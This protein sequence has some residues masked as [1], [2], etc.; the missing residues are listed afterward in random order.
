MLDRI[1]ARFRACIFIAFCL[2]LTGCSSSVEVRSIDATK[3][4]GVFIVG[5][6]ENQG[7]RQYFETTLGK[8]LDEQ[9][10]KVFPSYL[11]IPDVVNSDAETVHKLAQ[12]KQAMMVLVVSPE[13]YQG[14]IK[15]PV[16]P[17]TQH[18]DLAKFYEHQGDKSSPFDP[19]K[20]TVAEVYV[21]L[22]NDEKAPYY[23]SGISMPHDTLSKEKALNDVARNLAKSLASARDEITKQLQNK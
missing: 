22:V 2:S 4:S 23:W 19:D 17:P 6:S 9:G 15:L 18:H 7:S 12:D 1:F 20:Q 8:Y 14:K 5:F 16:K 10:F 21:F 11:Q 3:Q 13:N